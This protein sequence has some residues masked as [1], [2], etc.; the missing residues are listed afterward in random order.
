MSTFFPALLFGLRRKGCHGFNLII[1]IRLFLNQFGQ[2]RGEVDLIQVSQEFRRLF[3]HGER[4]RM[5]HI[6]KQQGDNVL[7]VATILVEDGLQAILS[8]LSCPYGADGKE[9]HASL[10]VIAFLH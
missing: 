2:D 10:P 8:A 9:G 6:D 1:Q 4:F 3:V 5:A 7:A